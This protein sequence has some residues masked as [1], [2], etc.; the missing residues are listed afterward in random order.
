M[1]NFPD[2]NSIVDQMKAR[3]YD[4]SFKNRER[5]AHFCG[6]Q[7]YRGTQEQNDYLNNNIVKN[8]L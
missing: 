7:D 1:N 6:I 3:G 5:L 8:Y 4:S 2:E